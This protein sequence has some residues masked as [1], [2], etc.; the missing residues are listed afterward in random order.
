ME[1]M[2]ETAVRNKF[3]FPFKGSVTVEDLWDLSVQDLDAVF[4]TLNSRR[5]KAQEESLL[6][7]KTKEDRLLEQQIEIV[8]YIVAE[9]LAAAEA[10]KHRQENRE[11]KQKILAVLAN[12]Q[13]QELLSKTPAELEAMLA[14]LE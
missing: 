4:K 5:K 2:F 11:Q 6:G 9:K 8:K 10:A 3:R 7:T 12:K 14:E 13:E 1:K